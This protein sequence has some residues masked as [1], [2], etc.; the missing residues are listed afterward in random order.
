MKNAL[1]AIAMLTVLVLLPSFGFANDEPRHPE[2]Q[3]V[4][5]G[6]PITATI[7]GEDDAPIKRHTRADWQRKHHAL[8][9]LGSDAFGYLMGSNPSLQD[10]NV[11]C[12]ADCGDGTMISCTGQECMVYYD[13]SGCNATDCGTTY[14]GLC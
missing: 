12:V 11:T 8:D 4:S 1:S 5:P 9:L 3:S 10:E 6:T 7:A 13:G 14:E 2:T